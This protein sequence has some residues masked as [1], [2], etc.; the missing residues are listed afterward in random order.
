MSLVIPIVGLG[1]LMLIPIGLL[2]WG[3]RT[4]RSL[5]RR[6]TS[7]W[8]RLVYNFGVRG[9]GSAMAIFFIAGGAFIGATMVATSPSDV[10]ACAIG[11]AIFAAMFGTPVALGMGYLWGSWMA[12]FEGLEPDANETT[13]LA[14]PNKRSSGRDA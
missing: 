3:L 7:P 9:Y 10:L 4:C 6:G 5:W 13:K 11:G 12:F 1:I 14:A 2:I 8:G